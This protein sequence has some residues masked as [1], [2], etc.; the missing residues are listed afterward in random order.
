MS[1]KEVKLTL[2]IFGAAVALFWTVLFFMNMLDFAFGMQVFWEWSMLEMTAVI[3]VGLVP[4]SIAMLLHAR[5]IMQRK[6]GFA[7]FLMVLSI[8]WLSHSALMITIMLIV[9]L[10]FGWDAYSFVM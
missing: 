2:F 4:M 7:I 5:D 10:V 8:A 3:I 9:S 1:R 6:K